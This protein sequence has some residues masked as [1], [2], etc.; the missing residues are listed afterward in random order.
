MK[1]TVLMT[2]T[3][4]TYVLTLYST[5]YYSLLC[6]IDSCSMRPQLVVVTACHEH[7]SSNGSCEKDFSLC[8]INSKSGTCEQLSQ[9]VSLTHHHN[10]TLLIATTLVRIT[11]VDG[12]SLLLEDL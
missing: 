8:P 11:S 5:E 10:W 2:S 12:H 6:F 4:S 3:E 7:F 1:K 9:F